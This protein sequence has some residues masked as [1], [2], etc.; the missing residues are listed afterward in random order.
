MICPKCGKEFSERPAMSRRDKSEICPRCG[1]KEAL[2]D[3][4]DAGIMTEGEANEILE[5]LEELRK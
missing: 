3:A 4:L 2:E 1:N 5:A